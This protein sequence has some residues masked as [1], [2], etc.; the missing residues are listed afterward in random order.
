M[1]GE[2]LPAEET[3]NFFFAQQLE[4]FIQFC[5]R[6]FRAVKMAR[7]L[8]LWILLPAFSKIWPTFAKLSKFRASFVVDW[9][10][11]EIRRVHWIR[12]EAAGIE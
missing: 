6:K 10:I 4:N 1:E 12:G 7:E 9:K 5:I 3:E 8:I 2:K 11:A